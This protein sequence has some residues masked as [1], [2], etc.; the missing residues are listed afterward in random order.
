MRHLFLLLF[1]LTTVV[2]LGQTVE[3]IRI[4]SLP[5]QGILLNK[6]WKWHAGDNSDWA[7]PE[8]DDSL[9]ESVDPTQGVYYLP[10]LQKESVGWLRIHLQVDST[11]LNKPLAFQLKQ[12]AASELFLNGKL[13][14]RYGMVSSQPENVNAF[15]PA[16]G[17]SGLLFDQT[18]QVLSVRFSIQKGIPYHA[19]NDPFHFFRFRIAEVRA[20]DRFNDSRILLRYMNFIYGGLFFLLGFI[21]LGFFITFPKQKANVYFSLFGFSASIANILYVYIIQSNSMT[22]KAYAGIIDYI[23]LLSF[24]SLF[25]LLA[26]YSLFPEPKRF[27]FWFLVVYLLFGFIIH[28]L[29]FEFGLILGFIIPYFLAFIEVFRIAFKAYRKGKK[30]AGLLVFG[31]AS[32]VVLHFV[33]F[34]ILFGILPNI[35]I[36]HNFFLTD[37]FYHAS[38]ICISVSFSIYLAREF[39]FTSKDLEQ[40]LGEVQQ[41]SQEKQQLLATQNETLEKQVEERTFQL[42]HSLENLKA[43]QT[44]LIQKEKMASLGELTAGIAH[45]IQNPLN[46]VNNFSEV[47]VELHDELGEELDR[48]D[49][50]EAK[51][52][53]VDIKQNLQKI[54]QH[55]Q[56][57]SSIVKGMLEHSRT[58]TG[59]KQPTDLNALADEYLRLAYHGLRAKDKDFNAELKTDFDPNLGM[60]EV[61]P[62]ELGRVLLNLFNNAF[63]AVSE[64]KKQ[65]PDSYQPTVSVSTKRENGQVEIQVRDNGTGMPEAVKA[66]IFQPFFT[67]KPTG[68]G[69]GLGLSLSYDIVTKG[70]GGSLDVQSTEGAGSE[71]VIRLPA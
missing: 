56:R 6:G 33:F 61:V 35:P 1:L 10:Q 4:D 51:V 3:P 19:F 39:A 47:S 7:K 65:Q 68:Q 64:N 16:N 13:L 2:G 55:G 70:H 58:S 52:I 50:A 59:D 32:Y 34:L 38:I 22:F 67:A 9:W 71:F 17:P 60:V 62:Q 14:Q 57:A 49:T 5:A 25:L 18:N 41:L 66:K 26:I 53:A 48:G 24:F 23:F 30:G 12:T 45:E 28:L 15:N 8:F 20:T 21:H 11:L 54:T 43:T 63:Y 27:I 46:F 40:K 36:G 69:T 31:S 37:V 44:Q 42:N 29:T